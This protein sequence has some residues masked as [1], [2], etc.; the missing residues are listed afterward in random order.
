MHPQRFALFGGILMLVIGAVALIPALV[1]S[2]ASLP[3]LMNETSYGLFLGFF[4]MNVFNKIALITF[5]IAGIVASQMK[6]T[7]LPSSIRYSRIVFFVFGALAVLG[8]IPAT[9]TLFGYWPLFG[10]EILA[11]AAFALVGAYYGYALSSKVPKVTR[12]GPEDY[13]SPAHGVR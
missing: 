1:G 11:H 5:G 7:E 2:N 3:P 10:G 8:L 6:G 12:G 9:N 13:R 4:P